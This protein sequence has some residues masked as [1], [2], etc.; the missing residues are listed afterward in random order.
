MSLAAHAPTLSVWHCSQVEEICPRASLR[1]TMPAVH[2]WRLSL[3]PKRSQGSLLPVHT[4]AAPAPARINEKV[5][6]LISV[7]TK[8]TVERRLQHSKKLS[9]LHA[10]DATIVWR[11][12]LWRGSCGGESASASQA[13][14]LIIAPVRLSPFRPAHRGGSQ[15]PRRWCSADQVPKITACWKAVDIADRQVQTPTVLA[16]T[17]KPHLLSTKCKA[18]NGGAHQ[19]TWTSCS[20]GWFFACTS[21]GFILHLGEFIDAENMG[22][23]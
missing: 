1:K 12:R 23:R 14:L 18:H 13:F 21:N 19:K 10:G 22:Q 3:S 15:V 7:R 2:V 6:S 9:T 11:R 20:T 4:D 8:R 17:A 5:L 16:A